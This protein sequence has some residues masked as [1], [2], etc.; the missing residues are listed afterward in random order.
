MI[1]NLIFDF[2]KVLVDYDFVRIIHSFF[3]DQAEDLTADCRLI[4]DSDF[5]DRCDREDEPLEEIIAEEKRK[6][7][8]LA[9]QIQLFYDR[10]DEFILGEMEGMRSLLQQLKQKGFRLYGLTNW[11][12]LVHGVMRKYEIFSLLDGSVISSEEHVIKPEPEIYHRLCRKFDLRPEECFF[13]DDKLVN[14]EGAL[15]VGMKAAV[16]TTAE[17]YVRDLCH[18][19]PQ[20]EGQLL[21]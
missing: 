3:P 8:H 11:S 19:I 13:A 20:L 4:L 2:G 16:F 21:L 6:H 7:P 12:H 14:V 17:Q 9:T 1:K 18:E 10:F 15:R 5:M